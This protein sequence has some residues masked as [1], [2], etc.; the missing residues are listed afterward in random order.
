MGL[1]P[2]M[3]ILFRPTHRRIAQKNESAGAPEISHFRC[4]SAPQ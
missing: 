4:A 2:P 1:G 3:G